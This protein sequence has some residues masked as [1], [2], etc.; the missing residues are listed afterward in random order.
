[1]RGLWE[2]TPLAAVTLCVTLGIVSAGL[3]V[4]YSFAALAGAT[5]LLLMAAY[6]CL[7]R[8][9]LCGSL[10]LGLCSL[11]FCGLLLALARRDGY[12][13]SDLR[14]LLSHASFPLEEILAFDG[15]VGEDA[16]T[17]GDETVATIELRAIKKDD[18]WSRC[19]GAGILKI[20]APD[21]KESSAQQTSLRCGDRVRGWATWHLPRNYRNPGS[22]DY[23]AAM[24]RRGISLVGRTKSSR[25]LEVIPDECASP[26][27]RM[28]A[29][30]R[31]NV[32]QS[33]RLLTRDG[34]DREAAI[35]A[36]VVLGDY[37]SLDNRTR[38]VFQNTG[39]YHVLV[40]SGLHVA[41][42]AWV[43][44]RFFQWIAIPRGAGRALSALVILCYTC[45]VGF[46]AS[47]SRC[48]WMFFLYL[49]GQSLF[50]RASPI[51]ILFASAL[52]LLVVRPDWLQEAGFQLSFVCVLAICLLAV[53][54]IDSRLRPVL[55][56]LR[57]VGDETRL[58]LRQGRWHRL[59]RR[60][61]CRGELLAEACADRW[62]RGPSIVLL[63]SLRVL[64]GFAFLLCETVLV[65][66]SVQ[67]WLEIVLAFHFNRL[68]WIAPI[69]NLVAVPASSLV[70]MAGMFLG[71]AANA[72][73]L[74]R[75]A[76]AAAGFVA[77][78]LLSSTSWISGIPFAWQRCPT[79]SPVW[80]ITVLMV[81]FAWC[82]LRWR[83][84]WIPGLFVAISLALLSWGRK[85][86]RFDR[87]G[88][89][90][91]NSRP[92]RLTFL[93]V[94]EGDS[95]VIRF[96][97]D[98]VWMVDSAGIHQSSTGEED[99]GA[100]DIGEAVVSRYLWWEWIGRLDRVII[101]HPD[102]DHAGGIQTLLKNFPTAQ[103]DYGE[104]RKDEL[105]GR[106]LEAA[107]MR[108][109]PVCMV[110]A[111][112]KEIIAGVSVQV[113]SPAEGKTDRTTNENSVVLRLSYGDFAAL[114]TGDLEKK[115][116]T[117]LVAGP[118]RL[119]SPLLKVAHHGS[120]SATLDPF[121]ERVSPRWAV[122]SVGRNNPFGHP[123]PEVMFRLLR[124]RARP[125]STLD[126][127]AI[128][129]ETDGRNYVISS[130][131]GGLLERGILPPETQ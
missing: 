35:L 92:L 85:P 57:R 51:N 68:S 113:L 65:S 4:R 106:I 89:L 109:V 94:G 32:R 108:G 61:R 125:L 18:L 117:E 130:H 128:T 76:A 24:Q 31:N 11:C 129:F 5:L 123:S 91:E 7:Q 78:F 25:L 119:Q 114:L 26:W 74:A 118:Y 101:S 63:A 42:L 54:L 126:Q 58:F 10:V 40:V 66:V 49:I 3:V 41:W 102:T 64:S 70:L 53:P 46:Q 48:L 83:R 88:D 112:R 110:G 81:I 84:F 2:E 79:P 73:M 98:R 29:R 27:S 111:G 95:I 13:R 38:E 39:T 17:R 121:L 59:G 50:R 36:S 15:C 75:P 6:L 97:D 96:P 103:L 22:S 47:I 116:E 1:M 105:L 9:R 99:P 124:H 62:G 45:V 12:V 93:D 90:C 72:P 115:G 86:V 21:P 100:F 120:R 23:A 71:L 67:I 77:S 87:L 30:V 131:F 104:P 34:S 82:F 69:A 19:R 56:P 14:S 60:M 20:P 16:R 52:V 55:E 43:C 44:I 107:R 8:D 28:I 80:V 122:I 33:I 127:G 37:S